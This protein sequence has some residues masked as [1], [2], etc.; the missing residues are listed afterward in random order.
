MNL[1]FDSKIKPDRNLLS[2]ADKQ[3]N[4]DN[5]SDKNDRNE[6]IIKKYIKRK[7]DAKNFR[8]RKMP[9]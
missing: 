7:A 3:T 8:I 1:E 2:Y 9:I 5:N 4:Q 6:P